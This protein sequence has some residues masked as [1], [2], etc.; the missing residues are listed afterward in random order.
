MTTDTTTL[1]PTID[2]AR[3]PERIKRLPIDPAR[4]FP[5][6]W[7]VEWIDGVPEFR[8]AD[9]RKFVAAITEHRCWVCGDVLGHHR[10][11]TIGPMCGLNRTT[12][13]PPSHVECAEW[14]VKN[15][16]FLSRPKM[17]RREDEELLNNATMAGI[18]LMRNPGVTLLWWTA[19][20]D[21]FT[22]P[23]GGRLIHIGDPERVA[24][25]AEGRLAT[26]AEVL[27]SIETGMPAL[28]E[29]AEQEATPWDR[30][31]A[32]LEIDRR[33]LELARYLPL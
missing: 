19:K 33:Y 32:H 20:Y 5:V 4:G 3:M 11:F 8:A 7:F 13:E 29:A 22:P 18:P 15:C 23:T 31:D 6:P 30:R 12:S 26:R 10:I 28:R 1:R 21:V 25:Y 16:P 14:S 24:W 27:R 17:V 9:A 2:Y